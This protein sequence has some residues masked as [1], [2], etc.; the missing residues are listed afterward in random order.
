VKTNA[1]GGVDFQ[2]GEKQCD[3]TYVLK[4]RAMSFDFESTQA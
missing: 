3:V 4:Y 2:P 1:K